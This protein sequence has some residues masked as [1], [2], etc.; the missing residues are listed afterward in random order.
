MIPPAQVFRHHTGDQ[1]EQ[2]MIDQFDEMLHQSR[3]YRW[4]IPPSCTPS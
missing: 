1:F 4:S 3:R 2:M